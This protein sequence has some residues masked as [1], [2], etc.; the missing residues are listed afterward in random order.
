M[1]LLNIFEVVDFCSID[2]VRFITSNCFICLKDQD[3]IIK[4]DISLKNNSD[5][6][7]SDS[8]QILVI[9]RLRDFIS[10]HSPNQA[11]ISIGICRLSKCNDRYLRNERRK[12]RRGISIFRK[13]DDSSDVKFLC[14]SIRIID[15]VVPNL[16]V[17]LFFKSLNRFRR[18]IFFI[19][20]KEISK[21]FNC[22]EYLILNYKSL[23]HHTIYSFITKSSQLFFCKLRIPS[24]ISSLCI[25]D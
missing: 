7:F 11:Q 6:F 15:N 24:S 8:F 10:F 23:H 21:L 4:R 22:R 3:L 17:S 18:E 2:H 19:L 12:S 13:A 20:R 9:K 14:T 1:F 16:K 5:H 25:C